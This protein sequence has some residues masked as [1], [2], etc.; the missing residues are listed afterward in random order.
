LPLLLGPATTA[1]PPTSGTHSQGEVYVD[2]NGDVFV[3]TAAGSPG[4]WRQFTLAAPEYNDNNAHI[5]GSLGVSGSVNFF[6]LPIVIFSKTL[7]AGSTTSAQIT[8]TSVGGVKV[9]SG[10]VAIIANL[11]AKNE[12]AAGYA[13]L[14]A[15]GI[16]CPAPRIWSTKKTSRPTASPSLR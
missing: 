11:V 9:P 2:V 13:T 15:P 6:A 10:A 12:A 16:L 4:T 7:T 8:G 3:C 5:S 1:G 14:W